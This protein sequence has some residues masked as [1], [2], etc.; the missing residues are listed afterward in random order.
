MPTDRLLTGPFS[1]FLPACPTPLAR[2]ACLPKRAQLADYTA[3]REKLSPHE[4]TKRTAL[5]MIKNGR[6]RTARNTESIRQV[7]L[8][9]L[10]ESKISKAHF[11]IDQPWSRFPW[12]FTKP[13]AVA[14]LKMRD[15]TGLRDAEALAKELKAAAALGLT[16][17]SSKFYYR[18][19][20][21]HE[22][23]RA[24]ADGGGSAAQRVPLAPCDASRAATGPACGGGSGSGGSGGGNGGST[25]V[26]LQTLAPAPWA[27]AQGKKKSVET[28]LSVFLED[29]D[30]SV[31]GSVPVVR[32]YAS[33]LSSQVDSRLHLLRPSCDY[34]RKER[35][36]T[37]VAESGVGANA[38][39][40]T[41]QH[42]EQEQEKEQEQEEEQEMEMCVI[43]APAL[44]ALPRRSLEPCMPPAR[45]RAPAQLLS[46]ASTRMH[47]R[48]P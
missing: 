28:A 39:M 37:M 26:M 29:V 3:E 46:E 24:S 23:M 4:T 14:E 44:C 36:I 34:A 40:E 42:R 12:S 43:W 18:A 7:A 35:I 20:T 30:T 41:E 2:R 8:R 9:S 11:P 31:S 10:A 21:L 6:D 38:G 1:P 13:R 48:L 33:Q 17:E 32:D 15:A 22:R 16:K 5:E 19:F 27:A 47:A 45:A 25:R